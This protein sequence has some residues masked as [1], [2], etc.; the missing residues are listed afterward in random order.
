MRVLTGTLTPLPPVGELP[1]L[2]AEASSFLPLLPDGDR[3]SR[4][5]AAS[6]LPPGEV[7]I[8]PLTGEPP[9]SAAEAASSTSAEGLMPIVGREGRRERLSMVVAEGGTPDCDRV[10]V[11][12]S[13]E[14]PLLQESPAIC[15]PRGAICGGENL[16]PPHGQ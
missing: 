6:P 7:S 2:A 1:S 10:S 14:E 11:S 15:R 9:S 5:A 12:R 8:R 4:V 3:L 16:H 13:G